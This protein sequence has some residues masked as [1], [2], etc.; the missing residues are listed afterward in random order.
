M[1][2]HIMQDST[3]KL[4]QKKPCKRCGSK[5]IEFKGIIVQMYDSGNDKMTVYCY[6]SSCGYRGPEYTNRFRDLDEARD[7]AFTLWNQNANS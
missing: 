3:D 1:E 7:A 6:C 2:V 4:R 5:L